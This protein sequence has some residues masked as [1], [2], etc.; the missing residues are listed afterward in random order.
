M[1]TA[2]NVPRTKSASEIT[3]RNNG[4]EISWSCQKRIFVWFSLVNRSISGNPRYKAQED[5][6][7]E[8]QLMKKVGV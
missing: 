8:I 1:I 6:Y 4:K 2:R 7:D 3:P 5:Y